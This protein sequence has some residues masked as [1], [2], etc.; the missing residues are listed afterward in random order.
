MGEEKDGRD[1]ICMSGGTRGKGRSLYTFFSPSGDVG[2]YSSSNPGA[3]E[4]P[5][6]LEEERD[7]L[8]KGSW[9]GAKVQRLGTF[10]RVGSSLDV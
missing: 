8:T 10:I 6:G 2:S 7:R 1:V 3:F 9:K 5:L 4:G